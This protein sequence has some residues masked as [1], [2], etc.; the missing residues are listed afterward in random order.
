MRFGVSIT[1]DMNDATNITH[2][3]RTVIIDK[4]GQFVKSYTGNEW[5]PDE[6]IA[7]V[8]NIAG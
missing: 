5:K 7:A 8:R 2:N 4:Q 1:R 6:I 3:L